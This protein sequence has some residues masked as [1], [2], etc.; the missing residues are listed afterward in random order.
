G[1]M[2]LTESEAGCFYH[3]QK[4]AIIPCHACGRFLC[5]LCD[6]ELQGQHLCPVCLE[7]GSRKGKLTSLEH[8][9]ILYDSAA[10]SVAILPILVWPLTVFTG[11]MAMFM[12]FRYWNA[13]S[14]VVPRTK[15]R[16]VLAILIGLIQI[17]LWGVLIYNLATR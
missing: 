10:L 15:I 8:H 4:R 12:G 2:I 11:P 1:E 17:V 3:P 9:R 16:L 6:V 7:S 5:G 14:S 13:P